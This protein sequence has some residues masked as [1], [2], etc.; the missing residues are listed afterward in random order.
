MTRKLECDMNFIKNPSLP[1][2]LQIFAN[3]F[4]NVIW[5]VGR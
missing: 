4:V 1:P 2:D 3:T 5:S